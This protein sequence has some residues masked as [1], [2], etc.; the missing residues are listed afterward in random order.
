MPLSFY[1]PSFLTTITAIRRSRSMATAL[2]T[3]PPLNIPDSKST[4][5]VYI[6][7]TTAHIQGIPSSHFFDPEIKGFD[8]LD[9][10]ALSFLIENPANGR[11]LLWDLGVRRD[12]QNLAP[13]I[14]KRIN[15]GGWTVTV[16]KDV[17]EILKEGGVKPEDIDSIIWRYTGL[18]N[19]ND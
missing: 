19:R 13:R 14:V 16:E 5:N 2:E 15:D 1:A 10:P 6:I 11:K 8:V 7:N 12:W 18:K 17:A 9:C 4:V 3:P